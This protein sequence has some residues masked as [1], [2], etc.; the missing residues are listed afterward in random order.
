M[1]LSLLGRARQEE[2]N[3]LAALD[4]AAK[5]LQEKSGF[6]LTYQQAYGA[7]LKANPDIYRRY[8]AASKMIAAFGQLGSESE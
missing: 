2:R 3:T 7:A 4:G 5:M 1:A 8:L 6:R